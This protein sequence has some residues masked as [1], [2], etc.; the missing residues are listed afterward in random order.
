[1]YSEYAILSNFNQ[2]YTGN[3]ELPEHISDNVAD[4]YLLN[5][6]CVDRIS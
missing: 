2:S 3:F 1:M 4:L 5:N 6:F